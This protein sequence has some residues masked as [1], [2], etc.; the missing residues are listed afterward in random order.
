MFR[1]NSLL[2]FTRRSVT[3]QELINKTPTTISNNV[4][5]IAQYPEETIEKNIQF[6]KDLNFTDRH[7][8]YLRKENA[9]VF[10]DD[11]NK[12]RMTLEEW[13]KFTEEQFKLSKL[14]QQE[15]LLNVPQVVNFPIEFYSQR[16][17]ELSQILDITEGDA[18][19]IMTLY[20]KAFFEPIISISNRVQILT[21]LLNDDTHLVKELIKKHTFVLG[22]EDKKIKKTF[23]KLIEYGFTPVEVQQIAMSYPLFLLRNVGNILM[24]FTMMEKMLLSRRQIIQMCKA[25]PFVFSLDYARILV[26]KI[27]LLKDNR[28]TYE[29]QGEM[30]YRYP[31]LLTKSI[32]SFKVKLRYLQRY[33]NV[34]FI[35]SNFGVALLNYNYENFIKPRGDLMNQKEYTNWEKVMKLSDEDF[36]REIGCSLSELKGLKVG[37][38]NRKEIDMAKYKELKVITKDLWPTYLDHPML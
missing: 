12:C 1:L 37:E 31:W 32:N 7:L 22:I 20:P 6:L 3:A 25:N 15:I 4:V 8:F 21:T 36:C 2:K 23:Y 30:F 33:H 24:I 14:K 13:Y 5:N 16:A 11:K 10:A 27:Q 35:D 28:F 18:F 38:V 34:D 9:Y 29:L 19:K 17:K 26:P